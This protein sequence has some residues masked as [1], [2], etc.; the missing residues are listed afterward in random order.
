MNY[1]MPAGQGVIVEMQTLLGFGISPY[2]V[3][4]A[5]TRNCAAVIGR[6]DRKGTVETGK[7]ADLVLLAG[8]PL[9]NLDVFEH[10]AG[11]MVGGRWLDKAAL[12]PMR[13]YR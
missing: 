10:P 8:N 7:D 12:E 3:L 13:R 11:V 2:E 1:Y 5:A 4:L 9:E 6:A